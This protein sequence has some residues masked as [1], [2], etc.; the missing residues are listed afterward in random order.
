MLILSLMTPRRENRILVLRKAA[1]KET[2]A[3]ARK[4]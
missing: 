2:N 1:L 3:A 4:R